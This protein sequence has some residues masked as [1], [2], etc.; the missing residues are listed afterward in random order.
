MHI[1]SH[2]KTTIVRVFFAFAICALPWRTQ[3]EL[4]DG[5]AESPAVPLTYRVPE[6]TEFL[7]VRAGAIEETTAG[8]TQE[9]LI[10]SNTFGAS[11]ISYV[12]NKVLADD[13]TTTVAN[14]CNLTRFRFRVLGKASASGIGGPYT[15][16]YALYSNC[17]YAVGNTEVGWNT[18]KIPGTGGEV[19]LPDE[20]PY[21]IEHIIDGQNPV[22]LPTNFYLGMI[23]SRANCS[24]VFG[25]AATVGFSAD[26]WDFPNLPC[27]E[28]V[29][30]YPAFPHASFWAELFGDE[31]CADAYPGYRSLKAAAQHSQSAVVGNN[32]WALDDFSLAGPSCDMIAYEV[33]VRNPGFYSFELREECNGPAIPGTEKQYAFQS[34]PP[35]V[36]IARFDIDPPIH[37]PA[38]LWLA[39][40][41]TSTTGGAVLTGIEPQIGSGGENTEYYYVLQ[42]EECSKIYTGQGSGPSFHAAITCLGKPLSGACCDLYRPSSTGEVVCRDLP[43]MNCPNAPAGHW[44]E[45]AACDDN[46][47]PHPCGQGACCVTDYGCEDVTQIECNAREPL[48]YSRTWLPDRTCAEDSPT[49]SAGDC[50]AAHSTSGCSNPITEELA[51]FSD[52]WCCD[53]EWDPTCVVRAE[54][55]ATGTP[56]NDVCG[57]I[58]PNG[59]MWMESNSTAIVAGRFGQGGTFTCPFE[60]T[61]SGNTVWFRFVA[62]EDSAMISTCNSPFPTSSRYLNVSTDCGTSSSIGCIY[63]AALCPE[64]RNNRL[65]VSLIPG[66]TYFVQ[67]GIPYGQ[68]TGLI[69]LDI[70]SPCPMADRISPYLAAVGSGAAFDHVGNEHALDAARTEPSIASE[71][72]PLPRNAAPTRAVAP[73]GTYARGGFVSVQVNVNALGGNIMGDAGNQPSIVVDPTNPQRMAMGWRQFNAGEDYPRAAYAFSQDGGNTWQFPGVIDPDAYRSDAVLQT[74]ADGVFYYHSIAIP[75]GRATVFRSF[76]HGMSWDAGFDFGEGNNLWIAVDKTPGLGRG[77]LY[78]ISTS[79]SFL[80]GRPPG[81]APSDEADFGYPAYGTMDVDPMGGV[82]MAT[83]YCRIAFSANAYRN[84]PVMHSVSMNPFGCTSAD[85][86]PEGSNGQTWISANPLASPFRRNIYVMDGSNMQFARSLDRGKSWIDSIPLHNDPDPNHA[87]WFGMMGVAPSGRLDVVWNDTRNS[88]VGESEL[89]YT[90]SEDGGSTWSTHVPVS[91]AFDSTVGWPG[92]LG[93]FNDIVSDGKGAHVAYAATFNGEH[94]VYYLRLLPPV[95][96][97]KNGVYDLDDISTG[98]SL[99]TNHDDVP[100]ECQSDFD[101][102]GLIDDADPDIDGDGVLNSADVCMFTPPGE[103]ASASGAARADTDGNCAIDLNDYWR[104]QN[105][106]AGGFPGLPAPAQACLTA[107]DRNADGH[108]DLYDLARM[109]NTFGEN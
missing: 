66:Q 75:N 95:D 25:A 30:G 26:G 92:F 106:M 37:L 99:D 57:G 88:S 35:A 29:G 36:Q 63:D 14:G 67:V 69:Q 8:G 4:G 90:Y 96:C 12:A 19:S 61:A 60:E 10:Y 65:C 55:T 31:Q 33:G 101:G 109:Q 58:P 104:L 103:P 79:P 45:G 51:C 18:V 93:E 43:E 17:P 72:P 9:K 86:N 94:D 42:G 5:E 44:I 22:P 71:T 78:S 85:P 102:D 70:T 105:C 64:G 76:D 41:T 53:T 6:G 24:P 73:S 77:N 40:K 81:F 20:G 48:N 7:R 28:S 34:A 32:V 2:H 59:A 68:P 49:C 50:W 87:H 108:V 46:P 11:K 1:R 27:N 3:A 21:E 47:F 23:F 98:T 80:R 74:D 107:F 83:D 82:W 39:A 16:K 84:G 54:N 91:P 56:R 38:S 97:N 52:A 62:T 15:V 89:F 100:D 13:I